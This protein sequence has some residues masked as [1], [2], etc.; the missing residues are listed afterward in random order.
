MSLARFDSTTDSHPVHPTADRSDH[1]STDR[2]RTDHPS[3]DRASEPVRPFG[4]LSFR[5]LR[6]IA[7]GLARVEQPL[8]ADTTGDGPRSSRLIATAFYDVWLITWPA[9]S[10]LEPHDHGDVRSVLQIVDGELT[11][12]Y[13]D[14]LTGGESTVRTLRRGSV[15]LAEPTVVHGLDNRSGTDATSLHVYSPPLVD[16]TFFDLH[17]SG[18]LHALRSTPVADRP[19]HATSDGA[20]LPGSAPLR[21]V[22]P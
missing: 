6:A 16:V 15:T 10:G 11:E 3:T 4:S 19:A 8:P 21:L 18:D 5:A 9:G 20:V 7:A 17:P 1:P 14:R 13:S 2:H 22:E 12:T